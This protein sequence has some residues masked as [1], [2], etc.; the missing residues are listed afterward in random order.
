[1]SDQIP[2]LLVGSVQN[3]LVDAIPIRL[4]VVAQ[5]PQHLDLPYLEQFC[6]TFRLVQM[7]TR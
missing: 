1:M 2:G 5:D 4:L 6:H 7:A 3:L